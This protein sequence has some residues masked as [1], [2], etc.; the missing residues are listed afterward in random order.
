MSSI[1]YTHTDEAP[2]LA[3][4][5]FLPIVEA[6][7]AKA[8]VAF[9][10]RDIS[11]AARIL[12]QFGLAD[13]ALTEL[14]ELAKTPQANIIKLPNISASIPQLK[15]AIK[16]LQEQGFAVPDYPEAPATDEEKEI[17]AKYDKVKGSAVNPVLREG[18]SDRR[19]PASVKNYA[20]THPHTNKPFA[21][22]SKTNVA[23]MGAHDFASNEKSVTL[24][25][26]D[27]LAIVLE[28]EAGEKTVLKSGLQVLAGEI[29][30]ATKMDAAHLRA[31]LENA[32]AE[33]KAQDV[34]FSVHLKATM[35][36]VSDPII[37]GHVVKAYFADV[38]AQYGD[39]LAAAGLSANDGLGAI[40]AGLGKLE[41]GAEINAAF[42]AALAAG[43]RLSYVNSDKGITN[44]HVPSDV[45]VDASM[46]ALVR[47]G[48]RL[49]GA[50]GGEDDTLA[51]IPD[52]SYAGVYQ[53]V[54]DDVKKNGPL[55]PATIGTVPN[56]GLMAQAAEEYGSHDK[57]FE[58][59]EA[60]TV[61]VVA[62]NGDVLIEHDVAAGDIWRACQ[63]K[64][65]PVQDWVKLAVTRAR[66]SQTPAIFWLNES[67]AHDAELIKKVNAYLPQHD[68]EGLTIEILAPTLATAYSLERMRKGEDTISV[69][70][71]VLRDYNTDLFPILELGTSAKM[72]SVVP[73]IAG[74]GLFETGA[75]GSAPKH[76]QQ[77]VE[78]N[79]LRWDSL[80]EFFALVPSL[81]KYAEQADAP[82]AQVLADALDRATGTFLNEDRSPGRKLGTTDN[83]GSH[84]YLA[85]YWAEELANQ[86]DDADLAAAFKPLAESLRAGEETIAAELIAVQG[87]PADIGGYYRPD[88]EKT[89]AVM[90]PS[91]TLNA[92][93]A[94]F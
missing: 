53:A 7:A 37:F 70:G 15:A 50:D 62:S 18:N 47:N 60:G 82:A 11:V 8:G 79:Y 68:T 75:G 1:I 44:L 12:A 81:E 10:T 2:L 51:V 29:I 31:F 27:V 46:P 72:L 22:G 58:I 35:M 30:D 40:L 32:L 78:E 38:F 80:G 59:A 54:I 85:L 56:V 3:T 17:R 42:E 21:E 64:D 90:R 77:L 65:I 84:F 41:N 26:D 71:N 48:G 43:P 74:G 89:S 94:A 45:I 39:Q 66:A 92:A 88:G 36:K 9:E 4:Y 24:E 55:D 25:Q 23:T 93:L 19:A 13:D 6:F 52:S 83:R 63:T 33:A 91:A 57:T 14:G 86:T 87:K 69:T 20:K 28:N 5:S 34:L 61:R 49:W 73:L 67:R 16:E 76:V